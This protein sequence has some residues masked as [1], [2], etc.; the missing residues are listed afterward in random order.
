MATCVPFTPDYTCCDD[1]DTLDASLQERATQLAWNTIN[2]LTGGQIGNCPVTVRPCVAQPCDV[3]V[4]WEWPSP[5]VVEGTWV[6]LSCVP[7][8]CQCSPLCEIVLESRVAQIDAVVVDGATLDPTTYTVHNGHRVVRTDGQCWPSCQHFDRPLTEM[9]TYGVTYVPGVIPD[10][11][12]LWA[13]GVLACEYAKAC[14]GAKCRL[15]SSV[16]SLTRQGVS[17]QM[18]TALF[19]NGLVGIREVDAYIISL[20]PAGIMRP[21]SVWSPDVPW[22]HHRY[23]PVL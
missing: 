12:G 20:N 13:V 18:S 9:G 19:P 11:A 21:A 10:V 23:V 6:N 1:W 8:R 16:T 15:P 14:S 17:M 7:P 22:A 4:G 2:A 5:R 3:C